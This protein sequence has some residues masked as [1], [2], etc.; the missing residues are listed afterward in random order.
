LGKIFQKAN[1]ITN[2]EF[3]ISDFAQY[4]PSYEAPASFIASPVFNGS[5][6]IGVAIAQ[7]PLAQITEIVSDTT[8]L[9]ETGETILV[10]PDYLPRSDARF[11]ENRGVVASFRNPTLARI[12]SDAEKAVFE[13]KVTGV[14]ETTDYRGKAVIAA[15]MPVDLLGLN[16][17]L[18]AKIDCEE[19]LADVTKMLATSSSSQFQLLLWTLG[20][21]LGSATVVVF[22]SQ[23]ITR[24][25]TRPISA[26]ADFASKIAAGDLS[27]TCQENASDVIGQLIKS[28]NTMRETLRNILQQLSEK[29]TSLSSSSEQLSSTASELAHGAEETARQSATVSAAAEQMSANMNNVSSSTEQVSGSVRSVSVAVEEMTASIAEIAKSAEKAASVAENA[30]NLTQTS[31]DK[32]VTLGESADAIGKVIEV[33]Q[34][35]AEQT[36]LLALNATIEAA[37]AGDAGKGFAVVAT[38][39]KEL[40]KQTAAATDDIRRRIEAIQSSTNEAIGAIQEI[41]SVINN[42]NQVSRSIASAV[43]EQR[44]T[45]SEISRRV[46]DTSNSAQTITVSVAESA[47]ATREITT[48]MVKVDSSTRQTA[49]GAGLIKDSGSQ[50]FRLADDLQSLVRKFHL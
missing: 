14:L 7:I 40:A 41:Q 44:V 9:G 29:A 33:I 5:K 4:V 30:A 3:A 10:G 47:S 8:A 49:S 22:A 16:W 45:T 20:I 50:L 2:E 32:M 23:F 27:S 18:T 25:I 34:D 43:E 48:N 28:M 21:A 1:T 31:N 19:A 15:S 37:R 36:N 26:V 39:V 11:D 38:E 13:K 35:I 17:C 24:S 46:A 12:E 6:R 42:V